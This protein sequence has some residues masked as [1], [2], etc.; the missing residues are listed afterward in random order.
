MNKRNELVDD[1]ATAREPG[2]DG[3]G[4]SPCKHDECR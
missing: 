1:R 3:V 4:R 2:V